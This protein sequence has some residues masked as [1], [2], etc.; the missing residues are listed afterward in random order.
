MNKKFSTLMAS[1]LLMGGTFSAN[2]EEI[3]LSQFLGDPVTEVNGDPVFV[4][5]ENSSEKYAFGAYATPDGT[6]TQV[7]EKIS[8]D[9]IDFDNIQRYFWTVTENW[10]GDA[11][12][13]PT[14]GSGNR[15]KYQLKNNEIGK[16]IGFEAVG[17]VATKTIWG[18]PTEASDTTYSIQIHKTV[19]YTGSGQTFVT[20][21]WDVTPKDFLRL[22]AMQDSLEFD[23]S[24]PNWTW[25]FYKVDDKAVEDMLDLNELYNS[26]GFNFELTGSGNDEVVNLFG[27]EG[28]SVHAIRLN[29]N[30]TATNNDEFGFPAGTYFITSTPDNSWN[31]SNIPADA[32]YD[33]LQ[34]CTF[35]AINP[36]ANGF[37]AD[38]RKAGK[39]FELTEVLG[40]DLI[41]Y[42]K[43]KD[44]DA[45]KVAKNDEVSVYNACFGVKKNKDGQF[46]I[47]VK[48]RF[49][50]LEA[51]TTGTQKTYY[52][53]KTDGTQ[54][55]TVSLQVSS[56][57]DD[58]NKVLGTV[59]GENVDDYKFSFQF[60]TMAAYDPIQLLNAKGQA[61]VYNITFASGE[62][63]TGKYLYATAYQQNDNAVYAKGA[64]FV[65]PM[66]P[67][68]QFTITEVDGN[69][70]TFTNRANHNVKFTAQL[71]LKADGS[72][73][74]GLG[75]ASATTAKFRNIDVNNAGDMEVSPVK[76]PLHYANINLTKVTPNK[77]YGTWNVEDGTQ[78]TLKFA[79]DNAD[80]S[81]KLYIYRPNDWN[82]YNLRV[83]DEKADALQFQLV[84]E[85]DS[86]VITLPYA[87]K[88]NDKEASVMQKGDSLAYYTYRMQAYRDGNLQNRFLN[89][90]GTKYNLSEVVASIATRYIIKNNQDGSQSIIEV[91]ANTVAPKAYNY[92]RH[93]VIEEW[94]AAWWLSNDFVKFYED[95]KVVNDNMTEA[96]KANNVKTYLTVEAAEESLDAN[97][98]YGVIKAER[99]GTIAMDG[100]R[101]AMISSET[102]M[103]VRLF[104]TDNNKVT[105]SF[106]ITTGW[107]EATK[108]RMFLFNPEDSVNYNVANGAY[109]K[110]YQ[111]NEGLNKAMFK[112][113]S[114][115]HNSKDTIVTNVKGEQA[116]VAAN[117][118]NN[119]KV[120]AGL[121]RFKFQIVK[122]LDDDTYYNI[123]QNGFY[124]VDINGK[125]AFTKKYDRSMALKV[126][127]EGTDAPTANE[128]IAAGNVVVAGV[129][130]AVV[131]KGAEGKNVI[132]ST[133]L[134]KVVANEVVSSD[135][136]QIS[137]PAG[138]VVVSVD[139]ESF[140]VVVK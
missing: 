132:V 14:D 120:K 69:N 88:V 34:K 13:K 8:D 3:T 131:V 76:L 51:G 127:V 121:D 43:D 110:K 9:K 11:N 112:A 25:K 122:A 111:W 6:I 128:T 113:A 109:D 67:E 115:Y 23:A 80:T 77:F 98:A 79:R 28:K 105:P 130:G 139:G 44:T 21:N 116:V 36:A 78:V 22:N 117:A 5:M 20:G 124:L 37:N 134:G 108:E 107:N 59:I 89:Y 72:F 136:A 99:G 129:N 101:D 114:F 97:T 30:L 61:A 29:S 16:Y 91:S 74:L 33:Y 140:K 49:S 118:S 50:Y 60:K 93:M 40:S 106:Y 119:Q 10:I 75:K 94:N 26:L 95:N 137:A 92:E 24:S 39:G 66:T 96:M 104:S 126:V 32:K 135:N 133:I 54:N 64:A 12:S 18:T 125:M 100:E 70:V 65:D 35:I 81:N 27:Q 56:E 31:W 84:K 68:A 38:D 71:F 19:K 87:Y 15:W 7:V 63:V 57:S 2:A 4:V 1:L 82:N 41:K 17:S 48:S 58:H 138:I 45:N 46:S 73:T 55:N 62:D 52:V 102:P 83:T 103:I 85:K 90:D 42:L 123:R 53:V 47:F 86:T